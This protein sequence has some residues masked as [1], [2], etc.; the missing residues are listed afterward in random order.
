MTYTEAAYKEFIKQIRQMPFALSVFLTPYTAEEY[1]EKGA[2][3][4]LSADK[5]SGYALTRE[6][7]LISVFSLPGANQGKAAIKSAVANGAQTLDCIGDF[8]ATL[9]SKFGFVEYDRLAW[10]DQYAPENW[11]Y[12]LRG[13]PDIV[14]MRR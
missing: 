10:D 9:Y 4:Y 3:C 13:R 12:E 2:V 8:L 5:Q 6:Y 1:E 7:D 14:F 11:D